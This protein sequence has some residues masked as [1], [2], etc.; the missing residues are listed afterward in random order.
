MIM[1]GMFDCSSFLISVCMFIVSKALLIS[2]ATVI[3]HTGGAIWLNP[4]ATVLFS[5]CSAVTVE[6]CALYPCCMGVFAVCKEEGSSPVSLQLLRGGIWACM[7]CPC[8]CLSWFWDRDYVSQLPCVRY[9]VFVKSSFK[10]FRCLIF[11]LSGPC[12]L[13]FLLC[14]IASWT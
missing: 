5:V 12:E 4:F 8:L 14:F 6:C 1:S 11:N 7:R 13:L 9:Y 10:R 3:V 2:S